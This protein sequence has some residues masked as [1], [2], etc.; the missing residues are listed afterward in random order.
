M[1]TGHGLGLGRWRS[2]N[3]SLSL[4]QQLLTHVIAGSSKTPSSSFHII[5]WVQ[6]ARPGLINGHSHNP[7]SFSSELTTVLMAP[8][9]NGPAVF[10]RHICFANVRWMESLSG[11]Y[12][13]AFAV[14]KGSLFAGGG[15]HY[16]CV[17]WW[18]TFHL[19]VSPAGGK[20]NKND[21]RHF[22]YWLKA[23]CSARHSHL[24]GIPWR[25]ERMCPCIHVALRERVTPACID[26]WIQVC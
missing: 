14:T 19:C 10:V 2:S 7:P 3:L 25:A 17:C 20:S 22:G 23:L 1:V 6:T 12:D 26:E 11:D 8:R 21:G 13:N 9:L 18:V 4:W 24:L 16:V 15:G 5:R